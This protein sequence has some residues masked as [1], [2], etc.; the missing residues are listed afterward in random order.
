MNVLGHLKTVLQSIP[1]L[2]GW[3]LSPMAAPWEQSEHA[4]AGRAAVSAVPGVAGIYPCLR[5][6]DDTLLLKSSSREFLMLFFA[7]SPLLIALLLAAFGERLHRVEI[8]RTCGWLYRNFALNILLVVLWGMALATQSQESLNGAWYSS[9]YL[10]TYGSA[11]ALLILNILAL[12]A[13]NTSWKISIISVGMYLI[14]LTFVL[15]ICPI[16]RP[17]SQSGSWWEPVDIDT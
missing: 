7:L 11:V 14:F 10:A 16:F 4:G 3:I 1:N 9:F 17:D 2:I 12:S 15:F 8:L 6:A 5:L 13:A